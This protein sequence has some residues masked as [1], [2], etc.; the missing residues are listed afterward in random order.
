[1]DDKKNNKLDD[2]HKNVGLGVLG[3]LLVGAVLAVYRY[4]K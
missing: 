4:K 3:V 2:F 1:M